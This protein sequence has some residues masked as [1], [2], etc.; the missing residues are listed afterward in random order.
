MKKILILFLLIFT[1]YAEDRP[2]IL[3]ILT[4]DQRFDNLSC[5]GN[6]FFKTP[7]IDALAKKGAKFNNAFVTTSICAASRASIFTG[8]VESSHGFTFGKPA[9]KEVNMLNSYP[10]LLKKAGYKTGFTGKFGVKMAKNRE[11]IGKMFDVFKPI[12]GYMKKQKDGSFKHETEISGDNACKMMEEFKGSPFCISVSFNATH[13]HDGNH[14]PGFGHFPWPKAVDNMYRD[15][16]FPEPKLDN[17][18]YFKTLPELMRNK[19]TS[20][21]RFRYYWR[22]DTKDKYQKNMQGYARMTSGID[23]VVGKMVKKLETLGLL[24]KTIIIYTADNG[25]FMGNRG[26][27]GKWCHFEESLRIPLVIKLPKGK[28]VN[29][30]KMVLNI[31]L[32]ATMIDLAGL[33]LP[34]QYQGRSLKPLLEGKDVKWRDSFFCEHQMNNPRIPKWEGVRTERF[35]YAYYYE[36]KYEFFHDLQKDPLQKTNMIKDETYKKQIEELKKKLK[37]YKKQYQ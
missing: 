22:W 14:K 1:A 36:K 5:Y 20:M 25:Y 31:D 15:V 27:A 28:V 37:E 26:F 21:N 29:S 23:H 3:F 33:E 30:N 2:N 34:A 9:L 24:D 32:T 19:D 8:M 13:A 17:E 4:D 18:E 35:I 6:K 10:A 12:W 16:K 7:H 11:M